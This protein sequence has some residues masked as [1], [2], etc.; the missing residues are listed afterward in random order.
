[1]DTVTAY[2]RTQNRLRLSL[3]LFYVN[4]F[5]MLASLLLFSCTLCGSCCPVSSFGWR[6]SALFR[7]LLQLMPLASG[8]VTWTTG[9]VL[10]FFVLACWNEQCGLRLTLLLDRMLGKLTAWFLF[11]GVPDT[12]S[13]GRNCIAFECSVVIGGFFSRSVVMLVEITY[14]YCRWPSTVVCQITKVGASFSCSILGL[15][16]LAHWRWPFW[17]HLRWTSVICCLVSLFTVRVRG[18]S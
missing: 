3:V 14:V 7:P 16:L 10:I 12:A 1:M 9:L 6:K 17:L 11:L 8:Y 18:R 13:N 4:L 2:G 5:S 15:L